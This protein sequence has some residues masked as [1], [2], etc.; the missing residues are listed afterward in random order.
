MRVNTLATG[1]GLRATGY[2]PSLIVTVTVK[3]LMNK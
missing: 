2:D 3:P 1:Y